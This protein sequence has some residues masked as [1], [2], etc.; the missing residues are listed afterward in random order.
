L[1]ALLSSIKS[2]HLRCDD[3]ITQAQKASRDIKND[4]RGDPSS[5]KDEIYALL[6]DAY[7]VL[8]DITRQATERLSELK[9]DNDGDDA[10]SKELDPPSFEELDP[11]QVSDDNVERVVA[12]SPRVERFLE[13]LGTDIST[14]PSSPIQTLLPIKYYFI[15]EDLIGDLASCMVDVLFPD[16][17]VQFATVSRHSF[18]Q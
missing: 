6:S 12:L 8:V 13:I 5:C 1:H 14:A 7:T 9:L 2:E 17:A 18:C 16:E 4:P 11:A 3:L 10:G 15:G